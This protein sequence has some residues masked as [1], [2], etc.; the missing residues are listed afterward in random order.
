MH[1][2]IRYE[3]MILFPH[4]HQK[5]VSFP[6]RYDDGSLLLHIVCQPLIPHK[7]QLVRITPLRSS[8]RQ[9][10]FIPYSSHHE[11][12]KLATTISSADF[13]LQPVKYLPKPNI[14][15]IHKHN[16][17][18]CSSSGAINA[19]REAAYDR[20]SVHVTCGSYDTYAGD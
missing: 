15:A 10:C 14:P 5:C 6:M 3:G 17:N 13:T 11:T 7:G 18:A 20:Y 4:A 16:T 8:G 19:S 12:I 1:N 9:R 2:P